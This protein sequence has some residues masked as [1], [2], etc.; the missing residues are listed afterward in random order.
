MLL[1]QRL[2]TRSFL[3]FNCAA[4][5]FCCDLRAQENCNVEVKLLLSPTETLSTIA[6][7]NAKKE[8]TGRIYFFDTD[9]LD[10]LSQG[11]IVRLRRGAPS[12]LTVKLRP[13]DGKKSFAVFVGREGFKCEVDL[14][15]E[16]AMSSY[17]I[18]REFAAEQPSKTGID[19]SRLL[20]PD[21]EKLLEEAQVSVNWTRVKRIAEITSTSWQTQTQSHLGKLALELW[22]WPGGKILEIS[23]RVSPEAG[24]STY[25]ELQQLVK[26]KQL[27]M[28]PI[29]GAKTR[30]A[31]EAITRIT[32]H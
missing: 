21:Q 26:S 25:T 19:V 32:A 13:P 31:L 20:G 6:A 29:Q 4:L 16:G 27:S 12:D 15:G 14:T 17:S 11:A 8:T 1:R 7:F 3:L 23:K 30:I 2:N 22:E 24:A 9:A 28:S 18:R 10:L 5:L